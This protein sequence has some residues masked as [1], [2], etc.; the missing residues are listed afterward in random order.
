MT[1]V[2]YRSKQ[3]IHPLLR[4]LSCWKPSL[5][6]KTTQ[7]GQLST[8]VLASCLVFSLPLIMKISSKHMG[9][10]SFKAFI[11]VWAGIQG[12]MKVSMWTLPV[13]RDSFRSLM[14]V[15]EAYSW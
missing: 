11:P 6:K 7:F 13:I 9:A 15:K 12:T 1:A 10:G 2:L 5:M 14:C 4:F 8:I 3:A